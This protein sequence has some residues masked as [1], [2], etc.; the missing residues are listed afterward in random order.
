ME[1]VFVS[2]VLPL[3]LFGVGLIMVN[4]K[5]LSFVIG[6]IF[7]AVAIFVFVWN[8]FIIGTVVQSIK[9]NI[10]EIIIISVGI[11]GICITLSY[12]FL[13]R[14]KIKIIKQNLI[15]FPYSIDFEAENM[16]NAIN[17]LG[18]KIL[19]DCLIMPISKIKKTKL[20]GEKCKH[21]FYL[22]NN[23]TSLEYH[24]PKK[25]TAI[26]EKEMQQ[27]YYSNFRRYKF[28]STNRINTHLYFIGATNKNVS[29]WEFYFKKFLYR[30]FKI[31]LV[32]KLD[33]PT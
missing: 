4:F 27:L 19:L 25:F 33:R 20:C 9:Y 24:S 2:Y 8:A 21:T 11:V 28:Y 7:I 1:N 32:Y 15:E 12:G 23:D 13:K 26:A 29:F 5:F 17:S 3:F 22:N 16:G 14:N 30:F 6:L 18:G 31:G 10:P